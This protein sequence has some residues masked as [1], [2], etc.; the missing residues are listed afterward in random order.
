MPRWLN[1]HFNFDF[2][3]KIDFGK[4]NV[5]VL[6]ALNVLQFGQFFGVEFFDKPFGKDRN[7]VSMAHRAALDYRAF[8]NV[9]YIGERNGAALKLFR[10]D[11][12]S[13]ARRFAYAEGEVS[14]L[15]SH[16]HDYVPSPR[17]TRVFHEV[18]HHLDADVPRGLKTEG[19]N[20][21]GQRQIIIDGFRNMDCA[22]LPT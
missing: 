21:T 11:R 10:D 20:L 18:T 14:G 4:A 13:R 1:L 12:H 15:A 2:A 22:Y 6:V 9:A 8:D 19:W 17:R 16:R 7:A 5:A 3:R